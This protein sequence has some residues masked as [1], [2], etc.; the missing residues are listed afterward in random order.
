M[1]VAHT[2]CVFVALNTQHAMFMRH[3]VICGL[4]QLYGIFPRYLIQGGIWKEVFEYKM[5]VLIFSTIS[6]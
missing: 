2:E 1:S 3:I 5:C 4:T 6:F